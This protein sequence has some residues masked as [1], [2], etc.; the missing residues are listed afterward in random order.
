MSRVIRLWF[1]IAALVAVALPAT[2]GDTGETVEEKLV[3]EDRTEVP[4]SYRWNLDDIF[5]NLDAFEAAMTEVTSSLDEL[6]SYRGRLGESPE[7]VADALDLM[8][9]VAPVVQDVYVFANQWAHTDTRDQEAARYLQRAQGLQ[10]KFREAV[11]FVEPQIAKIPAEMIDAYLGHERLDEYA[12]LIDDVRRRSEHIRSEEIESI[13]AA[14]SLLTGAPPQIRSSLHDADIEWPTITTPDGEEMTATP[15]LFY[16]FMDSPDRGFRHRA[17]EAIFGTYSHF[18]DTFANI[19][20]TSVHKDAWIADARG[21][22]STLEMTLDQSNIPPE[23]LEVLVGAVHDNLDAIHRYVDLRRDVMGIDELHIYDLYSGL[24]SEPPL[25]YTFNEGWALATEFWES[26]LGDEYAAVAA[27]A[28]DE[29]WIDVY[30]STGKRGGAYSWGT[31]RVH[32]YLF[33]NWGGTLGDVFTL[34]HEMG[35]SIHS[36]F[37]SVNQPFHDAGYSLFVAEVAS[38]AAESLFFEWMLE[39]ADDPTERLA[40]LNSRLNGMVG[41]FLRQIFF[42]EFE[43]AIHSAA[44][45][46]EPLT[47]ETFGKIW[48]DLWTTYYGPHAVVDDFYRAGWARIPHFFRTYYVWNYATS[49]AA[50]E[51]IAGRFREGDEAAVDDYLAMLKLGGSVYPM[52]ALERAG[53]DMT[54]PDVIRTVMV[55]FSSVVDRIAPLLK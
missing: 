6:R 27:R 22:G 17:A 24:A 29:R 46:D 26:V 5:P 50:G 42:H 36:Y 34:V 55:R 35:H 39:R 12:H 53:V 7:V 19:L 47:Q 3:W 14:A 41:T 10:A 11:A 20:A 37:S 44:A 23:V 18:G 4:E 31:Y 49:F 28:L 16:T 8:F 15:S 30:T 13:L 2:A 21:Y 43:H 40:L 1:V 45:R 48:S 52:E 38:V 32:P 9:S 51:A 25:T 33:L 54:D